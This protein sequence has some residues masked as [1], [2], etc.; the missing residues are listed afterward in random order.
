MAEI[1]NNEVPFNEYNKL[2]QKEDIKRIFNQYGLDI[3]PV[4]I[5]IYRNAMVHV[6]Y[7]CKKNDNFDKGNENCPDNC[8]PLQEESNERLEFLGD[9]VMATVC[10]KYLFD[11]YPDRENEGF[12]TKMRTRLVNGVMLAHLCELTEIPKFAMISRQ[13]ELNQGRKNKKIL[14]DTFEA[15]IG[16]M[17]VDF[18]E[19]QN[20]AMQLCE[21]WIINLIEANLDFSELVIQNT[22][23]KDTFLKYFQHTFNYQPKFFEISNETSILGKKY[24]V[25]VKDQNGAIVS[26][27]SGC[28]KKNAENDAAYNALVYY[29]IKI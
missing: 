6:S 4:N 24:D 16:A 18:C 13:I 28:N 7:C 25:C 2:I 27:G 17:Y 19:N 26:V 20:N 15:F 3:E 23:Y 10:G 11:R 29:G 14:E 8:L 9:T 12:L 22:N 1:N 5:N 21:T